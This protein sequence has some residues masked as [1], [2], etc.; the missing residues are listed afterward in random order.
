MYSMIRQLII[1]KHTLARRKK[2]NQIS[3]VSKELVD[4]EPTV[5]PSTPIKTC[6]TFSETEN[7]ELPLKKPRAKGLYYANIIGASFALV[8][9]LLPSIKAYPI[10]FIGV[11]IFLAFIFIR[12]AFL[13]EFK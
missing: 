13:G 11:L 8:G 9:F 2:M 1:G 12:V 7:P 3:L 6:Y 10:F 5:L 4:V